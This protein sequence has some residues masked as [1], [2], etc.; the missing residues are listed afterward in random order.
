MVEPIAKSGDEKISLKRH[1]KEV[2]ACVDS[3]LNALE[4]YIDEQIKQSIRRAALYHDLGKAATGMQKALS[5]GKK[6]DFRHELLSV[7]ILLAIGFDENDPLALSAILTHHKPLEGDSLQDY[8][9]INVTN[10]DEQYFI[11]SWLNR[12]K[13]LKGH[14]DWIKTFI[15]KSDLNNGEN[16]SSRLPDEPDSLPDVRDFYNSLMDRLRSNERTGIE[17]SSRHYIISRGLLMAADHLVSSGIES[18]IVELK[19]RPIELRP[20]QESVGDHTGSAILEAPTGSGKTRAAITWA[21]KNRKAG[22][23]IFYVLPYQASINAMAKTLSE[24]SDNGFG[25]GD[26]AVGIIH[27]N[28]LLHEFRQHFDDEADN[29]EQAER[30]ARERTEQT[31]QFYR[32]IKV[33]T[34]YQIIKPLF[35]CRRF[36]IGLTEMLGGLVI[37]DEIHAYDPHVAALI[38][39][40]LEQLKSLDVRYLF[41]SA[42]L[43]DFLKT[44]LSESVPGLA[45]FRVEGRD[46]WERKLL[47]TARHK[48][49]LQDKSLE[50]MVPDIL[51]ASNN[52]TVLVVCNRIEQARSLFNDLRNNQ[53]SV[54][55]L[56]GGFTVEDRLRKEKGLFRE[57]GSRRPACQILVATQVVEVSLD[58]SF[59]TIFTEIAPVDDLL[60][61]FG[62][63]NRVY[64]LKRPADVYVAKCFDKDKLRWVYDLERLQLTINSAPN[65]ELLFPEVESKWVRDV[66][67]GGYSSNEQEKYDR[68]K[69]A[70]NR[71]VCNLKPLHE[72]SDE[73]FYDLFDTISVLPVELFQ[74]YQEAIEQKRYLV[75][76]QMFMSLPLSKYHRLCQDGAICCETVAGNKLLVVKRKYNAE[77]G[78]TD[79]PAAFSPAII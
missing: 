44:R 3:M 9:G 67:G 40:A 50:D 34:P 61:R 57:P 30:A 73:E 46:E 27:H 72:G 25:F 66:Y 16:M 68:A 18:P 45:S 31:R 77:V 52:G 5:S 12:T 76:A 36:E 79:E 8:A 62:R 1:S 24:D 51:K 75:A 14:W 32:P 13:E 21:L 58:I 78:L 64:E 53:R 55:L 37:F 35:G 65:G 47:S 41:M 48:L 22:E 70:F 71:V 10:E 7:A 63:V 4:P 59:D 60:Q 43:P 49:I 33:V 20:F 28:A 54:S 6:W 26:E 17:A 74:Q 29:Y 23:R 11:K 15:R 19:P 38:E 42:T 69:E 39:V 56:H 2:L